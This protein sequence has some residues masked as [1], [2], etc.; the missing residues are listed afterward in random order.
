MKRAK[1]WAAL[2]RFLAVVTVALILILV[3]APG[4]SAASTYKVLYQFSGTDGADPED[5][6]LA[7]DA[8]GNLY[9]TSYG[10]GAYGIGTVFE[11]TPNPDGTWAETVLYN[12]AGSSDVSN[13][14]AGVILDSSGNLYG[15]GIH[16]GAYGCGGVY[17]LS[18]NG[19]GTWSESVIYSFTGGTDGNMPI[20]GVIFDTSGNLYGTTSGGGA[21][22]NGVVFELTPNSD[23]TWTESVLYSFK[24]GKDGSYPDHGS[25]IFDAAGNLYGETTGGGKGRCG[26]TISYRCGSVFELSPNS[27]G[28]W[29]E[30][31]LY[32][33]AGGRDGGKP[34]STLTFDQSG[35]LY[36]T[37]LFG[38]GGSCGGN[39]GSGCGT[40]FQLVPNSK[41]GWTEHVLHRFGAQGGTN[42][43]G[44]L[45]FD[46][47][48]NLYGTAVTRGAGFC[49]AWWGKGCG[50]VY[51]LV[52]NSKGGWTE[53]VLHRFSGSTGGNPY[54]ML[55]FDGNGNIYGV[56]SGEGTRGSSGLVYEIT[57]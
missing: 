46:A 55:V 41:G 31:V 53:Q 10:G 4:A 28:T 14:M 52:P 49:Q 23:G 3:L 33:F 42:P 27:D 21:S 11:L 39:G 12:F 43:W 26:W 40:V 36:G 13:P 9:G 16:S 22:G 56:A 7:F 54:G 45:V 34:E 37:T 8:A 17:E 1:F 20:G 50:T 57:P 32:R 15:T 25:L 18:P 5:S 30:T 2:S 38:G 35:V 51:K 44:G 19:D 48:G 24:A 29:K 6:S 47:T